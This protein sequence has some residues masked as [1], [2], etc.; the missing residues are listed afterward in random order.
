MSTAPGDVERAAPSGYAERISRN[1]RVIAQYRA[2]SAE[3]HARGASTRSSE[4]VIARLEVETTLLR[5][6]VERDA[7]GVVRTDRRTTESTR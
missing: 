5:A 7:R 4:R 6:W 2:E 1:D 3:R